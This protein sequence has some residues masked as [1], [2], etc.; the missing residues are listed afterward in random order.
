MLEKSDFN[1]KIFRIKLWIL[2][3][4]SAICVFYV[5]I[6]GHGASTI[7]EWFYVII[8][9]IF[10]YIYLSFFIYAIYHKSIFNILFNTC[11]IFLSPMIFMLSVLAGAHGIGSASFSIFVA[12]I[13][14]ILGILGLIIP[15]SLRF[16]REKKIYEKQMEEYN[17]NI[18]K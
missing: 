5:A 9:I 10:F 6:N 14:F 8:A 1:Q 18:I 2:I 15:V 3:I 7:N 17:K 4:F 16:R 12:F 13:S 11:L